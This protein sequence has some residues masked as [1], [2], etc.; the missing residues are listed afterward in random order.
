MALALGVLGGV[1]AGAVVWSAAMDRSRRDLFSRN[2]LR[3]LAAL[4]YLN[5]RPG[6]DTVRLLTDYVRWESHPVLRR[7]GELLLRRLHVRLV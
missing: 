3:R 2:P 5:G 6:P 4:G 7:R 1:V